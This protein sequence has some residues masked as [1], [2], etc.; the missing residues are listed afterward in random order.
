[1]WELRRAI[2]AVEAAGRPVGTLVAALHH[3]VSGPLSAILM[4]LL[5]AVAAFGLARSGKLFVRTVVGMALGFAYF[6]ADNFMIAMG[7]FG[8]AP[9]WLA[10]WAPFLLFFLIGEAVLFRTEE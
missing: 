10:A 6:V 9:P 4:P 7:E 2:V 8:A 1:M 5:G 3:K